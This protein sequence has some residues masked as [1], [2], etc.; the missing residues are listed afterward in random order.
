[1]TP[2]RPRLIARSLARRVPT[3]LVRV[4]PSSPHVPQSR[5]GRGAGLI[6]VS[7][8]RRHGGSPK[9]ARVARRGRVCSSQR[10]SIG[11]HG[12]PGSALDRS[13]P[14]GRH[15]W[16]GPV[17]PRSRLRPSADPSDPNRAMGQ[18]G[19]PSPLSEEERERDALPTTPCRRSDRLVRLWTTVR[20]SRSLGSFLVER[21]DHGRAPYGARDPASSRF[22][23]PMNAR[24]RAWIQ[25]LD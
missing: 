23:S 13:H 3:R 9:H 10:R 11:G 22:R 17:R 19:P 8:R 12:A 24:R 21:L 14:R 4:E 15:A 2:N 18:G 20:V 6:M 25:N 7:V 5:Q 1:M 16:R